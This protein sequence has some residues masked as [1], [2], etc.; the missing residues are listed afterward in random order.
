MV[1][2][3]MPLQYRMVEGL[4]DHGPLLRRF[5]STSNSSDPDSGG[6]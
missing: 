4:V 1:A 5:D 6:E 2:R 3:L